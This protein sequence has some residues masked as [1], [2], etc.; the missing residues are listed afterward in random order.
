MKVNEFIIFSRQKHIHDLFDKLD[1]DSSGTLERSE[2]IKVFKQ[3]CA[4]PKEAQN[5]FDNADADNSGA[6]DKQEFEYIWYR[7]FGDKDL[8]GQ[9]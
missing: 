1:R 2:I 8:D 4:E 5:I 6:L 7:L 3:M 9:G